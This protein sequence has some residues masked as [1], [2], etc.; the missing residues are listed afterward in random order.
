MARRARAAGLRRSQQPAVLERARRRLREQDRRRCSPRSSARPCT[1]TWW[2]QRRGFIRNTLQ[3]G[4]L[5]SRARACRRTR[6]LRTTA[7]Y[8]RSTY[9]FVT[10]PGRSDDYLLRRSGAARSADRRAAGRRR[11]LPT[12]RR[13]MR[14]R[15]AASS[16]TFAATRLWR[17]S[18]GQ[19]AGAHHRGGR[20]GRDRHR[21]RL[22]PARR[23][24]RASGNSAVADRRRSR[25]TSTCRSCRWSTR[26]RWA[27]ARGRRL[28]A[29][30]LDARARQH[31]AG[32][33]C[34]P[35]GN[36]ACRGSIRQRSRGRHERGAAVA[37]GRRVGARR[38]RARGARAPRP[39]CRDREPSEKIALVTTFARPGG[40]R[41]STRRS[42]RKHSRTTPFIS[43]KASGC[44]PGSTAAAAM[45]MAAAASGPALMDDN[46]IYGSSI[47]NIV[48]T[49]R[50]GR[51]NGM[52]AFRGKVPDDQIW[53]TRRLRPLDGRHASSS[54]AAPRRNDDMIRTRP[55]IGCPTCRT[56]GGSPPSGSAA[57]RR[58]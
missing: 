30:E 34:H 14:S 53:Q 18:R 25:R 38:L 12:R 40:R 2:A 51:P 13:P 57:M 54:D 20:R 17:L 58:P 3:A 44:T 31:A 23:L 46:W 16:T 8:Y 27:C 9:V 5:R 32:D 35:G 21:R 6:M 29:Q 19:P 1:Y 10:A 50:E 4:T 7:P 48:A 28:C 15:G 56:D 22:G 33:R 37:P 45:P 42:R 39:N 47:E 41:A 26:S 43:A 24:L 11:R 36:T 55:R 49:I 52:P